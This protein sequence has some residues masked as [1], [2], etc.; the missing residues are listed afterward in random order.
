ME[1]YG[2]G[3]M[4]DFCSQTYS[5]LLYNCR[6]ITSLLRASFVLLVKWEE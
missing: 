3:L 1:G 6:E 5:S 2:T 4:P